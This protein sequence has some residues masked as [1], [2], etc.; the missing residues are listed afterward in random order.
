MVVCLK[1][2]GITDS[3]RERL[4]M[5]L[6]TLDSWT[7]HALS[8]CSGELSPTSVRAGEVGLNLNLVLQLC[9]FDGSSECIAGFLISVRISLP[10]LESGSSSL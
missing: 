1:H 10:L 9:L 2:V 5:S 4:T 8:T 3:V 7:V 6:K